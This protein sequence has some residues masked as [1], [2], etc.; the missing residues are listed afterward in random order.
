MHVTHR[1]RNRLILFSI[2]FVSICFT[3]LFLRMLFSPLQNVEKVSDYILTPGTSSSMMLEDL[4]KKQMIN[5]EQTF[6]LKLYLKVFA[7]EKK[8]QVGKYKIHAKTTPYGLIQKFVKGEVEPSFVRIPEGATFRQVLGLIQSHPE[9]THTLNGM[10]P[11]EIFHQIA[12]ADIKHYHYEGWLY[13]DTYKFNYGTRDTEIIKNA[14]LLMQ[15]K[16]QLAWEN[17]SRLNNL[18]NPYEALILASIIEKEAGGLDDRQ[19]IA[20][21]FQRRLEKKMRLQADPTVIYGLGDVFDGNLRKNDLKTDTPYNSYLR[22]GLPPTPISLP[23]VASL[24]AAV[25]PSDD[26]SLYFV[27]KGD[28]SHHFSATLEEHNIAV[29]KYQ[30]GIESA[31]D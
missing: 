29:K 3:S 8:I 26:E 13:P 21:V 25:R 22:F 20:G 12:P 23:S 27:S 5:V 14:I 31:N 15:S 30:L 2:F 24:N 9:I 11:K 16:L 28:G 17:R 4:R 7:F 1:K 6:F 18:I 10:S 19:Q